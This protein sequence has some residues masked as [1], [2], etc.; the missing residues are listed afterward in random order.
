[1]ARKYP[2]SVHTRSQKIKFTRTLKQELAKGRKE[3]YARRIA[4]GVAKG[5]AKQQARGHRVG[6][7]VERK[8]RE[9]ERHG[10]T[11]AQLEAVRKFLARFNPHG[12][13]GVPTEEDL[14]EH[15]QS[16]G[17]SEF[18]QYRKVWDEIRREY[19][20]DLKNGTWENKGQPYLIIAQ[21]N[22]RVPEPQW[23]YYH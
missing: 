5:K 23:M 6:E 19:L 4:T 7:H 9:I 21:D 16:G 10:I 3:S 1:M 8:A 17:Y 15:I 13:K 11:S 22:A 20:N 18:V 2:R 12:F 14:V